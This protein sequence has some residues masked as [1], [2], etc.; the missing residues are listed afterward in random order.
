MAEVLAKRTNP[1]AALTDAEI[2][3]LALPAERRLVLRD[4]ACRGLELRVAAASARNPGGARTWSLEVKG[5]GRQRRFTIGS[6]PD[7]GLGEARKR[8][9]RLR[10]E[11][12]EGRD[13]VEER[14]EARRLTRMRRAGSADTTTLRTLLDTF[15]RLAERPRRL[16]SWPGMRRMI[17]GNFGPLL[18]KAPADLTRAD[19]RAVLDA[20]VARDAPIAGKRAARYLR[21]VL[22]WAVQRELIAANPA[23]GLDLDELTRPEKPRERVLSDDELRKLWT[24]TSKA[25]VFGDLTRFYVLTGLRQQEAAA[26]RW[27]DLDGAV[28]LIGDTK[29]GQPHRLPLSAAALA[30]LQ[31]Q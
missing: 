1:H 12:L 20:A 10:A 31:A 25:A 3:G 9:G 29:S 18:D 14:R 7:V 30:I 28:A 6:Y 2:R 13:P 17:E 8:A 23:A 21:R 11:V 15:E 24:A 26:L 22:S 16:R 19:F 27:G 5:A 4:P